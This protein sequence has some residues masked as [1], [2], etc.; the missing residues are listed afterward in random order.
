MVN[1]TDTLFIEDFKTYSEI[2]DIYTIK[3]EWHKINFDFKAT[4]LNV[5]FTNKLALHITCFQ[6]LGN[7]T[8]IISNCDFNDTVGRHSLT[9]SDYRYALYYHDDIYKCYDYFCDAKIVI[10][11]YFGELEN[12]ASKNKLYFT[13]CNFIN[14]FRSRKLLLLNMENSYNT[15]KPSVTLN[16]CMFYSNKNTQ[17][18]LVRCHNGDSQKHCAS[19]YLKNTTVL[20]NIQE[21]EDIIY[22][23]HVMLTLENVKIIN[24]SF[25]GSTFSPD[26]YNIIYAEMSY[27]KY[28]SY[29]EISKNTAYFTIKGLGIHMCENS[30]LNFSSNTLDYNVEISSLQNT[31]EIDTCAIQYISERGNLDKEFQ[32]DQKLNYS[33]ILNC[34]NNKCVISDTDLYH[35]DWDSTSAFWTSSPL[36]VNQRFIQQNISVRRQTKYIC[37]C[38][39][40][41]THDCYIEELGSFYPGVTVLFNFTVFSTSTETA[42]LLQNDD[43]YF[44]CRGKKSVVVDCGKCKSLHII[45]IHE[46][47][48]WC[49]LYLT[50][51]PIY[52]SHGI[53]QRAIYT[54]T[55]L[56]CPRGFSLHTGEYRCDQ[57]LSLHIPSITHCNIDDQTIQCPANSWISAHT[58]NNSHSYHVSLHCPFD[59]CL[60]HSSHINLSTPDSQCQFN[61]S[62]LLCGQCQQGLSAVFGSSQC[63]KCSNVY[64]LI[65]IPIGIAGLALVLLLF[66]LNL[67]VTN[68]DVNAFLLYVNII[69]INSSIFF[70]IN[71]PDTVMHTFISLANLDL[72]ITTCFYNGMGEYAK[73]WLQLVFPAYL[74]LIAATF[75]MAS[76]YSTRIQRLT[77]RRALP[78]L[79]TL[80]LLSYTKL[81]LTVSKTL[82]LYSTI[83]HLPSNHTTLVWS[84]DANVP[85]IE[86]KFIIL[87]ITCA[88]LFIILIPFNVLLIF[89]RQLSRFKY[90]NYFKPLLDAYQG[91]YKIRFYFWTGLQLLLRAIIF[92][93]SALD[94]NTNLTISVI[95]L[96]TLIWLTERFSP[97]KNQ[98]NNI[99]EALYMLNL[100]ALFTVALHTTANKHT[101][102]IIINLL[103]SLAI[104][105]LACIITIHVKN[106]CNA[107]IKGCD[108]SKMTKKF[109]SYFGKLTGANNPPKSI[110]LINPVPVV[111]YNY[112]EFREPLIGQD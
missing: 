38:N 82:F 52:P 85:L 22:I 96:G 76:R 51:L 84:V 63:K 88:I 9:M 14:N 97:F 89:A 27:L 46:S 54:I 12:Y 66:I 49:E 77:A 39:D 37:L 78:V 8:V 95:L 44:A 10:L 4:I 41:K 35:C 58:V 24:N 93:L 69:G 103:I 40:N 25:A 70:P 79:A 61:R 47:G 11:L 36:Y 2:D 68:G 75:I 26:N 83:T 64:L 73:M 3:I 67:T 48:T 72:G 100:L 56:P 111:A 112:K 50:A 90:I 110:E 106:L 74:I 28:K 15:K 42:L 18:L 32:M 99:L 1:T 33:I 87:F 107:N 94:R 86:I 30:I 31:D 102:G 5:K 17:L 65:V 81:L 43:S 13:D 16:N 34:N 29:N 92:G 53:M 23:Y 105:K 62:G 55:F 6:C 57:V 80:F 109:S 21:K 20:S 98:A 71:G 60:P 19:I 104:F 45:L 101:V 59:Y 7:N 91:P 108:C